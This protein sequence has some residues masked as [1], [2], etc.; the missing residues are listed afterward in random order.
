V[1][2]SDRRGDI[3]RTLRSSE[4]PL[5]ILDIARRLDVHPNT[6]RFHLRALTENGRV[7]QVESPSAAPG[8]PPLMFRAHRGMDPA[9]PRNYLLLADALAGRLG[10]ERGATDNAIDSGRAVGRRVAE[11]TAPSQSISN[12]GATERLLAILE[13]LGFAPERRSGHGERAI[14]LRN[15]PFLEL[16]DEHAQVICPVHLGLMQGVMSSL[17]A[18]VTV[19]RLEPFAEP[20]VCMAHLGPVDVAR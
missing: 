16:I 13:D 18:T 15:C 5:S 9:G 8:R 12:E 10:G 3:L 14:G 20:D 7:E 11:T 17:G 6:V 4:E 1:I 19:Q 2:V